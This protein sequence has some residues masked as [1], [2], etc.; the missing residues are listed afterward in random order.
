[1]AFTNPALYQTERAIIEA[2]RASWV[3]F[4][5]Q[6]IIMMMLGVLAVIWPQILTRA[7]DVYIGWMFLFSGLTGLITMFIARSVPAFLW[8]LLTAALSL[9]A[10]VLLL[11][12][13]IEGAASLTLVLIAFVIVEGAFQIATAFRHRN[14]FL[15]S[16]G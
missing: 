12:H 9:L 11:W 5:M 1:M 6:G 8:S 14:A 7:A 15:Q 10:G 16:W 4:L 2:I 13:P 3:L